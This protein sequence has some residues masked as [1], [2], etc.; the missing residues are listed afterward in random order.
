MKDMLFD[1]VAEA[2]NPWLARHRIR[3]FLQVRLL[4][5]LQRQGAMSALA[6]HGGTALRILFHIPRFSEDLD[7]TLEGTHYQPERYVDFFASALSREGYTVRCRLK[8]QRSV[9]ALW[10]HFVGLL[11]E[12]GLSPHHDEVLA[13]KIEVDT[14]PP[15]GVQLQISTRRRFAWLLRLQHHNLASILA[16]KIH[17]LL[18]R[19][20]LKGRDVYDLIWLRSLSSPPEPNLDL[21]RHALQQTGWHGPEVTQ[22]NWRLLVWQRLEQASWEH[23]RKDV[24]PFLE[25]PDNLELLTPEVLREVLQLPE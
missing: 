17:A 10:V 25:H 16:G 12:L 7:F 19:P 3:E 9:H 22:E 15:R 24:E 23:I 2:Q 8:T 1:I 20:Y 6:F 13:I 21:V 4:H 11:H 14:R 5:L 18:Q